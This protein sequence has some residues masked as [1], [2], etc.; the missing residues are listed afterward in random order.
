MYESEI[1]ALGEERKQ[2]V[3]EGRRMHDLATAEKRDLTGPEQAAWDRVNA[4]IDSLGARM[5]R[6]LKLKRADEE[7]EELDEEEK[8]KKEEEE[9]RDAEE[10]EEEKKK[11]EAEKS[12]EDDD[13]NRSY[14]T[15][16]DGRKAVLVGEGRSKNFRPGTAPE[17]RGPRDSDEY[18]AAAFQFLAY[19]LPGLS[20]KHMR[21]IQADSD[22]AGGYLVMPQQFVA[23]LI[24]FVDNLLFIRQRATKFV[25]TDAQT[26]GAP[27][28]DADPADSDWTSELSTGNEDTTMAF[29]KRELTPHPLAKRLKV[30]NKL[31]RQAAI[32]GTFSNYDA[33]GIG[34]GGIEGLIRARLGYKFRVSEEES[35]M[36]G[37]GIAKPLGLFT[38]S[39]KGI[40]TARDVQTGSATG[41][42]ADNLIT[43]K[44][45]LK[46]QYWDRAEWIFHRDAM[47]LIRQLKDGI[48][49]Y[50][51]APGTPFQDARPDTFLDRPVNMSEYAP[52]TFTTGQY[53]GMLGDYSFYWIVDS[54]NLQIQ[55]LTE[56][57]AEA[58]QTGFIA[59]MEL[60]GMPVLEEAFVRLI[61]N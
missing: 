30:S 10:E 5:E 56:L 59:R 36:T 4:G 49:H 17:V 19:G 13:K 11:K 21:A 45:S 46:Q 58:N 6:L 14:V 53:V 27:S 3:A 48:G 26:L 9:G 28:L 57:Y 43:A 8:K 33:E 25:V 2:L 18:R 44:Y 52:N 12:P 23:Q 22:I 34:S 47:K 1:K 50:L 37:D 38:A 42:L 7:Q 16:P 40:S 61:T 41:F 31:M 51:W 54:L 32:T 35:F 55:R 20:A 60:D 24:K 15:L 29:G 39:S